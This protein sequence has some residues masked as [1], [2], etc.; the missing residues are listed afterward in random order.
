VVE[1][2]KEKGAGRV[3]VGDMSRVQ[4]LRFSPT[5]LSGSSRALMT[6]S[7]VAEAVQVSGAE[8]HCF[9]EHRWDGFID[10]SKVVPRVANHIVTGWLGGWEAALASETLTKNS[11]NTIWDDRVLTEIKNI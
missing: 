1:I 7:S 2:L 3:I 8:L 9:E 4:Y 11:L 10:T 6:S 5:S